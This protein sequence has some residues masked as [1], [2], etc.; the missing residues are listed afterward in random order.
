ML[1]PLGDSSRDRP[2]P[3]SWSNLGILGPPVVDLQLA[4]DFF[5]R[6]TFLLFVRRCGCVYCIPPWLRC[7]NF[8]YSLIAL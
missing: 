8:I 6:V 7:R 5:F 4:L 3:P 1:G 2:L